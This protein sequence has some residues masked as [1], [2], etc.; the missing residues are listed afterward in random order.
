MNHLR[1][2]PPVAFPVRLGTYSDENSDLEV[3]DGSE[4]ILDNLEGRT[5]WGVSNAYSDNPIA[6]LTETGSFTNRGRTGMINATVKY[7]FSWLVK[8]LKSYTFLNL[9]SY[10]MTRIGKSPDYLAYASPQEQQALDA[11]AGRVRRWGP[12][13][14]SAAPFWRLLPARRRGRPPARR[15]CPR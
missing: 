9:N 11:Y 14:G 1:T 7:D 5:I 13:G 12:P 8:G 4:T 15:R 3:P 2:I 10:L 6:A